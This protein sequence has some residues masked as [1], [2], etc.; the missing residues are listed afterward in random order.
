[1][2]HYPGQ[3]QSTP[4]RGLSCV[5]EELWDP[6]ATAPSPEGGVGDDGENES[7]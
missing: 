1:M 2:F 5:A 3:T 4:K 7:D 6:R